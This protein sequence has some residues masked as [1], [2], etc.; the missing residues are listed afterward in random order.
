M[1]HEDGMVSTGAGMFSPHRLQ[2]TRKS[3]SRVA[4]WFHTGTIVG[5]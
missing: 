1:I 4:G 2:T 3:Q 5:E